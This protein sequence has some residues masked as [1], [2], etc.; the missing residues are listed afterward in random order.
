[1]PE[2]RNTFRKAERLSGKKNVEELIRAGQSFYQFPF[3]IVWNISEEPFSFPAQI[4]FAVP[5]R[6][7]KSAVK[8]NRIKR[9]LRESY[10][11]NKAP[12]YAELVKRG[13]YLR[14]IIIYS[15]KEMPVQ[16]ETEGKIILTLRRLIKATDGNPAHSAKA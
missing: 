9:L 8:R 4:A 16:A 10:R 3:R 12:F 13:K 2:T 7:F 6:N 14:A 1:M 11:R 15:Q 5:K